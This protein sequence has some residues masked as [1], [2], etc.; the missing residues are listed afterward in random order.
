[1]SYNRWMPQ[2]YQN[3]GELYHYGVKGMKWKNR[4]GLTGQPVT[5]GQ[6]NPNGPAPGSFAEEEA[7]YAYDQNAT[8]RAMQKHKEAN[9]PAW[10]KK[11][12]RSSAKKEL[13]KIKQKI[14]KKFN[15]QTVKNKPK[16]KNKSNV[17]VTFH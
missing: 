7:Q 11:W 16:K 5:G 8:Y 17:K 1:M 10:Q 13:W 4:K 12:D 9:K 14:K 3:G 15:I 6:I 2:E